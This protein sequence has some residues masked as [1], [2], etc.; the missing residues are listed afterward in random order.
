MDI[1]QQRRIGIQ[2]S[3]GQIATLVL[4][5]MAAYGL[6]YMTT[7]KLVA[8]APASTVMSICTLMAALAGLY[9]GYVADRSK[10]GKR[11]L[12]FFFLIPTLITFC[13]FFLPI[14]LGGG[15]LAYLAVMMLLFYGCYYCFLTP[16]DA[17]G[18]EI[19]TDYNVRTFMRT[20]CVA[21]IYVGVIFADTLSTYIRTGLMS[22]GMSD[23]MSWFVMAV[24]LAAVSGLAGLFAFRATKG[25][26]GPVSLQEDAPKTNIIKSYFQVLKTKQI[27]FLSIWTILFYIVCMIMSPMI[28]YYGVYVLGLSQAAASTLYM[29]AV[30]VTLA[31]TPFAPMIAQKVGKKA[32][33]YIG[34]LV[35]IAFAVYILIGHP[36]GIV[37]GVIFAGTYSIVNTISQGCSYSMLY[38]AAEVAEFKTGA[39]QQASAMGLMKCAM[40]V[41]VALGTFTLGMIL[42]VGGFDGAVLEQSAKT[43]NWIT[44]GV[45]V[46]PAIILILS[47]LVVMFGYNINEKNHE[48]LVAA[49]E[50]RKEGKDYTTEGFEELI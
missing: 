13:L 37:P 18:G 14:D 16:F 42:S 49:L 26:G 21:G 48:A 35:Y 2:Y 44:Y 34:T 11:S 41:G 1:K 19:V 7:T 9:I 10:R 40:A 15:N 47:S 36:T 25:F 43:V 5:L 31:F 32:C 17:L 45:T 46:I 24:I 29:V 50:A 30:A 12:A 8:A 3:V 6:F 33:I 28:L 38:D 39:P 20:L 23:P 27:S 22:G 4:E